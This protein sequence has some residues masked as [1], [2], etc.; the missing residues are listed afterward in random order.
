VEWFR[1]RGHEVRVW[2]LEPGPARLGA[3]A[4]PRAPVPRVAQYALAVPALASALERFAPD[5]VDAHFVPNYGVMGVLAGRRPL[6]VSAW[7]SDLLVTARA[8]VLQTARARFVLER[9]DAVVT[10]GEN[11]AAAAR[12]LGGG[13]RVH[14]VPWGVDLGRFRPRAAREPGLLFSSRMHEPVYDI[15]TVLRGAAGELQADPNARLVIAGTGSGTRE[16]ERLAASVLPAGRY[17]FVGRMEEETMAAWLARAEITISASRSDSTSV[18][19]LEAMASGAIPV[20]SDI[21]GNRAWVADGEGARLFA[22][23][24]A[25][26]LARA[27]RAARGDPSWSESARARNRARVE[28]DADLHV[29]M[30]R[31]E[32]LFARLAGGS[33]A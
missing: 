26:G 31:I 29:N 9:A 4:L 8:N 30:A 1:A 5:V 27:L 33:L 12:R 13:E 10:D 7:G 19:L 28:R 6:V 17:E 14:L 24:D 2:S 25:L 21:E 32:R 20:V 15:P 22:P 23:G 11:L 18:S 3:T 16:L